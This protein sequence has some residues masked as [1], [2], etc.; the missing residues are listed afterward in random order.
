MANREMKFSVL[1]FL[2]V[3]SLTIWMM[4]LAAESWKLAVV[5]QVSMPSTLTIPERRV[6]PFSTLRVRLSPVRAEVSIAE[7]PSRMT[8]STGTFSPGLTT[9]VEPIFT[10]LAATATTE[11]S[12]RT[13]LAVLG[14]ILV[15][16]SISRLLRAMAESSIRLPTRNRMVTMTASEYS[17]I[18]KAAMTAMVN[19]EVS[20]NF[21]RQI[22]LT[23][24]HSKGRAAVRVASTIKGS[25]ATW[26]RGRKVTA[27]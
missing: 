7:P 20:S 22:F 4:R 3:E 2:A 13:R 18:K 14:R 12:G 17:P 21:S 19:R 1:P 23:P 15:S 25:F 24:P 8:Q 26:G 27:K 10:L 6:S 11:P 16:A 9:M 5:L